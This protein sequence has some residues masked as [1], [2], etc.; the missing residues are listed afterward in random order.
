MYYEEAKNF[1]QGVEFS[2]VARVAVFL[3][4][5]SIG[6]CG[7]PSKKLEHSVNQ[8]LEVLDVFPKGQS[9]PVYIDSIGA[10]FSSQVT[11]SFEINPTVDGKLSYD[12]ETNSVIFKPTFLLSHDTNYRVRVKATDIYSQSSTEISWEFRTVSLDEDSFGFSA[13]VPRC[14][15]DKIFVQT[16][17]PTMSSVHIYV[18]S[19]RV[20][21]VVASAGSW[22]FEISNNITEGENIVEVEITPFDY[23]LLSEFVSEPKKFYKKFYSFKDDLPPDPPVLYKRSNIE[24]YIIEPK[25]NCGIT[26]EYLLFHTKDDKEYLFGAVPNEF[27]TTLLAFE[28][29]QICIKAIDLVGNISACS[30][31]VEQGF[32]GME[33]K[34]DEDFQDVLPK[35]NK[36]F[37]LKDGLLFYSDASSNYSTSMACDKI[38]AN[39]SR[40]LC[41][42]NDKLIA[43]KSDLTFESFQSYV[44]DSCAFSDTFSTGTSVVHNNTKIDIPVEKISCSEEY[45]VG[46]SSVSRD[47]Y[48]IHDNQIKVSNI[49]S[50]N[51]LGRYLLDDPLIELVEIFP[52]KLKFAAFVRNVNPYKLL[53]HQPMSETQNSIRLSLL[54]FFDPF[55]LTNSVIRA[56][57]YSIDQV[58]E[59]A[60]FNNIVIFLAEKSLIVDP[61]PFANGDTT[62][63]V[64]DNIRSMG[65]TDFDGDGS[66][67]LFIAF[68]NGLVRIILGN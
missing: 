24:F 53:V 64:Y 5:I 11:F 51:Y 4:L 33:F 58:K 7:R 50:I 17:F 56:K 43:I 55:T 21:D 42:K 39:L 34:I 9:I 26:G 32:Q 57:E 14:F 1:L 65:L 25:D 63:V 38:F 54:L 67:E 3:L 29:G 60:I 23:S 18:N 52:L 48:I 44:S 49:S 61:K 2:Q 37:F 28:G 15:K 35:W 19:V 13:S 47:M 20:I 6:A 46:Y 40:I 62:R 66:S 27:D 10:K 30:N 59:F 36:L 45:I 68:E 31:K 16:T 41:Q 12:P 8:V 22:G